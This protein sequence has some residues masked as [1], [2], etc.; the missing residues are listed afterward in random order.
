M[1]NCVPICRVS[2]GATAP[3]AE[4]TLRAIA[5]ELTRTPPEANEHRK[6]ML[7]RLSIDQAGAGGGAS[8]TAYN[9]RAEQRRLT[10]S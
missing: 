6:R 9:V 3:E 4:A 5:P 8:K 7:Q 1:P 10:L 2:A